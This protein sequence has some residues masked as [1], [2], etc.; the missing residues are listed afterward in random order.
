MAFRETLTSLKVKG[1]NQFVNNEYSATL[2][3]YS[4]AL[5]LPVREGDETIR[6]DILAN[7][8][9][10]YAK[11]KRWEYSLEDANQVGHLQPER[12]IA[13]PSIDLTLHPSTGHQ[14]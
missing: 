2:D 13:M 8:S 1:N 6:R 12:R 11:L 10:A 7:R 4:R 3:T 5:S 14:D 9:A